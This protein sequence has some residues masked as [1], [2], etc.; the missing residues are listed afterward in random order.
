[1]NSTEDVYNELKKYDTENKLTL[2][3]DRN[4]IELEVN[5]YKI[6][7]FDDYIS[8]ATKG[9]STSKQITHWHPN[10][11]N[12]MYHDLLGILKERIDLKYISEGQ[13]RTNWK[14]IIT[15]IIALIFFGVFELGSFFS[16]ILVILFFILF[17]LLI[18][19]I[20]KLIIFMRIKLVNK[21]DM[22]LVK[23]Y[24]KMS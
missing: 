10:D 24:V 6:V 16:F 1:M 11:Y 4:G 14:I 12:E 23:K 15:T 21:E 8:V 17:N 2:S 19:G 5:N 3:D 22:E 18:I 7:A 9:V 13:L 20:K